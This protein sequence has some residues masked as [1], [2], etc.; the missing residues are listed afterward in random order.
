VDLKGSSGPFMPI[1]TKGGSEPKMPNAAVCTKVGF[2]D[3][4]AVKHLF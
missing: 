4:I 3:F 1:D 2:D